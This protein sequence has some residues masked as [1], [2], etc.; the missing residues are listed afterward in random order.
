MERA[1]NSVDK[2]MSTEEIEM[3]QKSG[4]LPDKLLKDLQTCKASVPA[5]YEDTVQTVKN[6]LG[7]ID[8]ITSTSSILHQSVA[9]ILTSLQ[10]ESE[11]YK[12]RIA[13]NPR[14]IACLLQKID[15]CV[16][17]FVGSCYKAESLADVHWD[18]LE[19]IHSDLANLAFGNSLNVSVPKVILS[20]CDPKQADPEKRGR[21][22][23][24][25]S[26]P[27]AKKKQAA[28]K[29]AKV[30]PAWKLKDG[31]DYALVFGRHTSSIP[32][33][34]G[35]PIC[36]RYQI[37]GRCNLGSKCQRKASHRVLTGDIKGEMTAWVQECREA[38]E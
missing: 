1:G 34:E 35:M 26:N 17:R 32:K 4:N 18:A 37:A 19:A 6:F 11:M 9:K 20:L 30:N 22:D 24:D 8:V 23:E 28:V 38:A 12:M 5:N 7:E 14:F 13:S 2:A 16:Q 29:N 3:R 36:A 31:E 10:N 33:F 25:D 21:S 15:V 27:R